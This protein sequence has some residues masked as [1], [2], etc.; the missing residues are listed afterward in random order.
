MNENLNLNQI[1]EEKNE[2]IFE[3]NEN[4]KTIIEKAA[5]LESKTLILLQENENLISSLS[6]SDNEV[7]SLRKK[8]TDLCEKRN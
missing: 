5:K 2:K 4:E 8:C 7:K 3:F 1:L 6:Y